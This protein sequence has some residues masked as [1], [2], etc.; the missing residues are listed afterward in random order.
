MRLTTIG[1]RWAAQRRQYAGGWRRNP[2][3][4]AAL[5]SS[6]SESETDGS[7]DRQQK[8]AIRIWE[9]EGGSLDTHRSICQ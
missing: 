6:Q 2:W 5:G 3:I 7:Q 9:N 8:A 1:S 4:N